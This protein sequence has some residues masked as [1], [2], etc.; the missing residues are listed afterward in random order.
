M[1]ITAQARRLARLKAAATRAAERADKA[2]V[3]FEDAQRKFY[4][5]MQDEGI[6][7]IK[8]DGTNFVP[9]QTTYGQI[10]DREAFIEWAREN[11][12]ELVEYHERK[13]LINELV[14]ERI[15]TGAELPPG[16]GFYVKE[17]VSQRV[18]S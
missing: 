2:K 10:Q 9:A 4:E 12:P 16:V 3:A 17:Y 5:Q 15:E 7:S 18:A 1:N 13:G 11:E 6:G 8:V 14:R